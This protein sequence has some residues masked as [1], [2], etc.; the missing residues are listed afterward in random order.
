MKQSD[1]NRIITEEVEGML[2][3]LGTAMAEGKGQDLADKYVAKLR[4]EFRKLNDDELD[5]FRKTIA[6]AF[7]LK[8]G[9]LDRFK[10][11]PVTEGKYFDS[12]IM[13]KWNSSKSIVKDIAQYIANAYEIGGE[14]DHKA[15]KEAVTDVVKTLQEGM[16]KGLKMVKMMSKG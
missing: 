10:K 5:E 4:S 16:I 1:L 7:D 11:K 2:S 12:D 14:G 15:G 9:T 6:K 3:M 13:E 8:E